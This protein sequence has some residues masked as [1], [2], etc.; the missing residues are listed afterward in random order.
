MKLTPTRRR[1]TGLLLLASATALLA[2]ACVPGVS[3]PGTSTTITP[4]TSDVTSTTTATTTTTTTTTTPA[5]TTAPT[6][7]TPPSDDLPLQ[8]TPIASGFSA[9]C[10]V[11]TSGGVK[12]WGVGGT[13]GVVIDLPGITNAVSVSTS[14][15]H[16]CVITSARTVKCLGNNNYGQLGNGTTLNS[17]APVDVVGVTNA[18]SITTGASHTCALLSDRT[19]KCWGRITYAIFGGT[20]DPTWPVPTTIALPAV[21]S[22]DSAAAHTCAVTTVGNVWCWGF[23]LGG[24]LGDG[25][26][27]PAAEPVKVQHVS[28]AVAISAGYLHS[29]AIV[30]GGEVKCWG[31]NT[32]GQLGD[33]T[34]VSPDLFELDYHPVDVAGISNAVAIDAGGDSHTCARLANRTVKC[35]GN[36]K[37]GQ[38]G[39]GGATSAEPE[40]LPTMTRNQPTPTQVVGLSGVEHLSVGTYNTCVVTDAPAVKCWGRNHLGQLG[41]AD[42]QP[43]STPIVVP[44]LP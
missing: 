28:G 25:T 8:P 43:S 37:F 24:Q 7:T 32:N 31:R 5:P 41:R 36:A 4:P 2:A 3:A 13:P 35:W 44:G 38:V 9:S 29:C 18:V 11:K 42:I 40:P 19:V 30:D 1:A 26:T 34:L 6:T 15:S 22:I 16:Y 23:N 20:N 12:C 33:G 21:E 17:S 27:T 14:G 10:V 39:D